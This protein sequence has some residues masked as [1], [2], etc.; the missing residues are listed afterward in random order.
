MRERFL[1]TNANT[2]PI[3]VNP[4][5]PDGVYE[6]EATGNRLQYVVGETFKQLGQCLRMSRMEKS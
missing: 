3:Y 1:I 6:G 5:P 2:R 4:Y